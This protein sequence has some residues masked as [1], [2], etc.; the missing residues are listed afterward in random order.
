MVV[1]AL[2]IRGVGLLL[3]GAGVLLFAVIALHFYIMRVL[4]SITGPQLS[5]SCRELNG[6]YVIRVAN[7]GRGAFS[8]VKVEVD[9]NVV[10]E[11]EVLHSGNT[12]VCVVRDVGDGTKVF[13][14]SGTYN[15]QTSVTSGV[16]YRVV[17]SSPALD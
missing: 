12:E 5:A 15:G 3:L 16:C 11:Y 14:V 7:Y 8:S 9:G 4:P 1:M 6:Q 17:V 13:R 2:D 10:C